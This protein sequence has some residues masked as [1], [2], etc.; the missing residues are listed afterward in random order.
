MLAWLIVLLAFF[1]LAVQLFITILEFKLTTLAGFV[2]VPF[3]LFGQTAFLAER[4]LGNVITVGHQADGAGHRGRHRLDD[5][6]HAGSARPA[7]DH[8]E[9]G[10]I[11]HPRRHRR[12]R[13][14]DLRAGHRRRS[15]HRRAATRCRCR[16]RDDSRRWRHGVAGGCSHR[17]AQPPCRADRRRRRALGRVALGHASAPPTKPAASR[18][19]AR[20]T[21]SRPHRCRGSAVTAPVRDAYRQGAA[22]GYRATAPAAGTAAGRGR[23]HAHRRH[24]RRRLRRDGRSA[25][26]RRQRMRDADARRGP[27]R[28]RGRPADEQ[29]PRPISKTRAEVTPCASSDRPCATARR[30]NR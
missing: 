14:R 13:T 8:A 16:G 15:G 22:Y 25:S 26:P 3:A 27:G 1:V 6:R 19:V 9:A 10:R 30:R 21:V 4:V 12:V 2:L 7:R 11:D 23:R 5:L 17:A 29:R 28:A 24:R 20:A 18:G